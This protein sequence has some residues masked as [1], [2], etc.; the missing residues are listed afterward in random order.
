[1]LTLLAHKAGDLTEK[2]AILTTSLMQGG[3]ASPAL[4]RFFIDDLAGDVRTVI[5]KSRDPIGPSLS[6]PRKLVADDVI[7]VDRSS[8]ELQLLIDACNKWAERNSLQW[9]PA[10]CTIVMP[11][12]ERFHR[13]LNLVDQALAVR[14]QAK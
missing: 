11:N 7:L 8:E 14:T 6:D 5:G 2:T 10:K 13:V 3:T 12:P 9:K 1:M 4:F